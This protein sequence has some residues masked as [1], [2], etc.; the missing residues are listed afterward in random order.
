[1]FEFNTKDIYA[2]SNHLYLNFYT[3]E[4]EEER[5]AQ[6]VEQFV[7]RYDKIMKLY[8]NLYSGKKQ[9]FHTKFFDEI[10]DRANFVHSSGVYKML[11]EHGL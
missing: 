7:R 4:A 10:S 9:G 8:F 5:D 3:P 1:M 6:G 11:K 2:E